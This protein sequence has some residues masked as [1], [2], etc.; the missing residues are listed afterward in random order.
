MAEE[1][2]LCFESDS[3]TQC[4]RVVYGRDCDFV[5]LICLGA[6]PFASSS[7]LSCAAASPLAH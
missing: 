2:W 5:V 3:S 4:I 1:W 7:L 6:L